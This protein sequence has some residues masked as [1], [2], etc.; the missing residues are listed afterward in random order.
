MRRF[1]RQVHALLDPSKS[2]TITVQERVER[3]DVSSVMFGGSRTP[4]P[5]QREIVLRCISP[6][7][8]LPC[9]TPLGLA[10]RMHMHVTQEGYCV[11]TVI[12][13]SNV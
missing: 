8:F 2:D 10:H 9:A 1:V 5:V 7:S 12:G 3:A 6:R 4:A 11:S 13:E